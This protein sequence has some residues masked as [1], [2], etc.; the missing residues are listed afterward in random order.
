MQATSVE[1]LSPTTPM[2]SRANV[3]VGY[4]DYFRAVLIDKTR[5]LAHDELQ[6]SPLPSGWTPLELLNHLA[7]VERR[8]LVWGFEGTTVDDPWTDHRDGRWWVAPH[9]A[10]DEVIE[11][12]TSQARVTRTIV[13]R[14]DLA[15]VGQ[16]GD[17][18]DGAEPATLER[19]LLHLL[20]E[21]ARHAGHLDVV[22][23]LANGRVGE[24]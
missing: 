18:W 19:V 17:R 1:F 21:Y 8:W 23:E 22:V 3:L 9:L 7:A 16:P 2:D 13:G 12:L 11:A 4:L 24:E 5:A 15:D 20:Q 6:S 10:R 14:H